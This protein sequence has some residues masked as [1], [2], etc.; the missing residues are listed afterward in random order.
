LPKHHQIG[1]TNNG[2]PGIKQLTD[3]LEHLAQSCTFTTING[4]LTQVDVETTSGA[5]S[6]LL[7][8]GA[9]VDSKYRI[10]GLIGQGGMGAIYKVHHLLLSKEMALKTFRSYALSPDLWQRFQREAQAIAKLDHKNIVDVFD[11]GITQDGL[12]YYTM[13]LLAGQ[14]LS[15]ELKQTGRLAPAVALKIFRQ[16]AEALAH[17][18]RQNIVHRDIKPGNIFL[19]D[20]GRGQTSGQQV[21]L[22]DFGIAKLAESTTLR[23]EIS[24]T[25]AGTI[26]GSP[27]YMSP[28]QS[29]GFSTDHRTDMYSFGCTLYHVLT[30]KPPFAGRNAFVTMTLHQTKE[31]P[32]LQD[33]GIDFVF[34]QRLERMIAKLLAKN[35]EDRYENFDEIEA[36]LRWCRRAIQTGKPA[37]ALANTSTEIPQSH[38]SG[39]EIPDLEQTRARSTNR[40]LAILGISAASLMTAAVLG[41]VWMAQKSTTSQPP[42][43]A[44]SQSTSPEGSFLIASNDKEKV[45]RFPTKSAIGYFEYDHKHANCSGDVHVPANAKI[46]YIADADLQDHPEWFRRFGPNDLHGIRLDFSGVLWHEKHIREIS[47]L[48]GLEH[49]RLSGLEEITPS[50][51]GLIGKLDNLKYLSVSDSIVKS[52]DLIKLKSL[53]RLEGLRV[54]TVSNL[55]VLFK[56]LT[57]NKVNIK[58]LVANSSALSRPDF[59]TI[60]RIKTLIYFSGASNN[61]DNE[62]INAL[63]VAP[64]WQA[65]NLMNNPV[66]DG[67]IDSLA[68]FKDLLYINL[69][70]RHF[71]K[72][73]LVQLKKK[74]PSNCKLL[75]VDGFQFEDACRDIL[76]PLE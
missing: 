61:I 51:I 47:R 48:T 70:T 46:M 67:A 53:P 74:L 49:L 75:D 6:A 7:K 60:A 9:V 58:A 19:I 14:S 43:T 1:D 15:D 40:L 28:E 18:H 41:A 16:I 3:F 32:S 23:E 63:E 39:E 76:A 11:F 66:S 64:R 45:F 54:S 71:S 8:N 17:A 68:K 13:E 42:S 20:E 35:P 30:G 5:G 24:L 73:G 57:T 34:P 72:G 36:E 26:V 59:L 25:R 65:L 62:A 29:L 50:T 33:S 10:I 31:A 27:L 21:K 37:S 52:D 44:Q 2:F 22:V 12:P 38:F 4:K 55:P 56:F 69:D